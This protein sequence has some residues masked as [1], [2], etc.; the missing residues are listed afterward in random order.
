MATASLSTVEYRERRRPR[1]AMPH[2]ATPAYGAR[3][4]A[5]PQTCTD[6]HNRVRTAASTKAG[7]LGLRGRGRPHHISVGRT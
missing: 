2:K 1:R 3:P 7:S 5:D 4:K 6:T